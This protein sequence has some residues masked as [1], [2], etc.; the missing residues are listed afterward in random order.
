MHRKANGPTQHCEQKFEVFTIMADA[1]T[2][3]KSEI[4]TLATAKGAR[5]SSGSPICNWIGITCSRRHKR[6]AALHLA[7]MGLVGS[8][9][10]SI[11]NFSF[12]VSLDLSNNNFHGHL[13]DE[14]DRTV[15]SQSGTSAHLF[16][17]GRV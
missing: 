8:I 13:P 9:P 3:Q 6:V 16:E 15:P 12:L 5:S 7:N 2:V 1:K 17:N 11:R 10:P 4:K 14:L